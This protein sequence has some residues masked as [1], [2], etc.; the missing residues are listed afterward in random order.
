MS[1]RWHGG[2]PPYLLTKCRSSNQESTTNQKT[3]V[4]YQLSLLN[5]LAYHAAQ[6]VHGYNKRQ[7]SHATGAKARPVGQ[8]AGT[9]SVQLQTFATV[10]QVRERET[11]ITDPCIAQSRMQLVCIYLLATR[12][13]Q[14]V[15]T[16]SGQSA[17]HPFQQQRGGY[18]SLNV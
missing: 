5:A 6:L 3:V 16:H 14:G 13:Q 11:C 18:Q 7:V 9:S 12:S 17:Q 10:L 2:G 15:Q 4:L 8:V 1:N